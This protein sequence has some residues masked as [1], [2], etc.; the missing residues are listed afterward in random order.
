MTRRGAPLA[1]LA[2]YALFLAVCVFLFSPLVFAGKSFIGGN[3]RLVS[4]VPF[5]TVAA[6][7]LA[8]GRLP[9][10]NPY[11]LAGCRALGEPVMRALY[12]P[13]LVMLKLFPN[14]IALADSWRLFLEVFAMLALSYIFFLKVWRD[15]AYAALS[16]F[17]YSLSISSFMNFA[18]PYPA[19]YAPMLLL[20]AVWD[21]R[22][23]GAA[24]SAA[25]LAGALFLQVTGASYQIAG[26]YI[27][28]A[29]V[30]SMAREA[31]APPASRPSPLRLLGVWALAG[32]L[33]VC[34]CAPDL[35]PFLGALGSS[36]RTPLPYDA[37]ADKLQQPWFTA[38]RLAMP[39]LF[40]D[41]HEFP[42]VEGNGNINDSE[43]FPAYAGAA[44]LLLCGL[45]L[46]RW[47]RKEVWPWALGVLVLVLAA[48]RS[49][50]AAVPYYLFGRTPLLHGRI[51]YLVP[52]CM[53]FLA[54]AGLQA[55]VE[56]SKRFQERCAATAALASAAVLLIA[57]GFLSAPTL[58]SFIPRDAIAA[59]PQF[60]LERFRPS[61]VFFAEAGFALAALLAAHRWGALKARTL[62]LACAALVLADVAFVAKRH[63]MAGAFMAESAWYP[64]TK[65]SEF[66]SSLTDRA[67]Y[68]TQV[69]MGTPWPGL[70]PF[71]PGRPNPF[72]PSLHIP[73]GL[74]EVNGYASLIDERVAALATLGGPRP[75]PMRVLLPWGETLHPK[76]ADLFAVKYLVVP[77]QAHYAAAVGS[78]AEEI[79]AAD[80]ALVFR[81]PNVAA[82]VRLACRA[83]SAATL[84]ETLALAADP[85]F[86]ARTTAIVPPEAGLALDGPCPDPSAALSWRE[87]APERLAGE[88]TLARPGLL[89]ISDTADA[90][91]SAA[92]DGKPARLIRVNHAF[93]GLALPAGRSSFV[94]SFR[95][96]GFDASLW[97]A[98][99]AA[100]ACLALAAAPR[101][102]RA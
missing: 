95:P 85:T 99:A 87:E 51:A 16:A 84:R 72:Q 19:P 14:H 10:W 18:F 11:S 88:A 94:M 55:F 91:W 30:V 66:L 76:V 37:L 36:N 58:L 5:F 29:F 73:Y 64:P 56:G 12:P 24:K 54:P 8:A 23:R 96:A 101:S 40:G 82:R 1:A 28:F 102:P 31:S 26:Y 15:E 61:A 68:R 45:A 39:Y 22:A 63:V 62:K 42:L 97:C 93:H 78:Y 38:L 75:V 60:L 21:W 13:T 86:D 74:R 33:S 46:A 34:L 47:R 80:G 50:I 90:G 32:A 100:L 20:L 65:V 69:M 49:P 81:R 52:L 98:A 3:D 92:V 9:L 89:V 48:V 17:A 71:A 67:E 77:D 70:P 57:G 6:K 25:F 83:A 44:T 43:A 41:Y 4:A 2:P 27:L 7:S 35:I 53:A 59:P 79:F